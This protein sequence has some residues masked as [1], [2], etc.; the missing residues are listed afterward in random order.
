LK[1][2]EFSTSQVFKDDEAAQ[3]AD[4]MFNEIRDTATSFTGTLPTY[5]MD[6]H[7][8]DVVNL[9]LDDSRSIQAVLT[10]MSGTFPIEW[11]ARK[12]GSSFTSTAVGQPT[13]NSFENLTDGARSKYVAFDSAIVHGD[14]DDIGY[15]AAV[16]V[17]E[18]GEFA[19]A[20]VNRSIDGGYN[21]TPWALLTAG[22]ISGYPTA[23]PGYPDRASSWDRANTISFYVPQGTAPASVTEAALLEDE[24]L[25]LFAIWSPTLGEWEF[26]QAANVTD[27]GDGTWS[28]D[29]ML[30]GRFGTEYV[31]KTHTTASIVVN[32]DIE[33]ITR[34][35][36][37]ADVDL[38]RHYVSVTNGTEFD[39]SFVTVFTNTSKG[40]RPWKPHDMTAARDVSSPTTGDVV[41][42][43]TRRDRVYQAWPEHG[44]ETLDLNEST[45][46]YQIKVR[47]GAGNVLRTIDTSTNSFTYTEAEQFTDFGHVPA[48]GTIDFG[49][50]QVSATYGNGL[51]LRVLR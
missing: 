9:P 12:R 48:A 8:G 46:A 3:V 50:A 17:I 5:H 35:V 4:I 2:L 22:L 37:D 11:E 13:P 18:D 6:L 19:S 20:I 36:T 23:A 7:P 43:I 42:T 31:M 41:G 26:L 32:T 30:R 24:H 10:K 28:L 38:E 40:K 49:I 33:A 51:E 1:T 15:Y 45:E 16:R 44:D 34:I 29:T 27:N 21:Y 14:H 39:E 25:N 47:D